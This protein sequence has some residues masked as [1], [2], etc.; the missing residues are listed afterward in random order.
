[1]TDIR[2]LLA[3]LG[4]AAIGWFA[5]EYHLE[6]VRRVVAQENRT[7][8]RWAEDFHADLDGQFPDGRER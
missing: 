8:R 1:M 2:N 7:F 3:L 5:H 6:E 4:L